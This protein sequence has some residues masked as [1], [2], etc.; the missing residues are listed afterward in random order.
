MGVFV[1]LQAIEEAADRIGGVARKT[2]L[3]P[4]VLEGHGPVLAKCENLQSGGA[5]KIRGAH[6]FMAQL[7]DVE[8]CRGVITYSSG[9]HAQAVAAVGALFDVPATVVMPSDAPTM[10]LDATRARGADLRFLEGF[11][12]FTIYLLF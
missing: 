10:K 8:R 12:F 3:V 4:L 1:S 7:S 5:F 2:P 6:N 9:N 11:Y